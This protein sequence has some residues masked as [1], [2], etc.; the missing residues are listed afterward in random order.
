MPSI[1]L[2][3]FHIKRF[4]NKELKVTDL[5]NENFP[6]EIRLAE[7]SLIFAFKISRNKVTPKAPDKC[8]IT[9]ELQWLEHLWNHG[10]LFET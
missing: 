8:L 6:F 5:V 7:L 1:I 2:K 10:N 4:S 9:V 3:D